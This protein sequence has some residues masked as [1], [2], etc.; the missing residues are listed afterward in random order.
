[1]TDPR[2]PRWFP[3]HARRETEPTHR[4]GHRYPPPTSPARANQP[5]YQ[6]GYGPT[7][8]P[9]VTESNPT[10]RLPQYWQQGQPPNAGQPSSGGAPPERPKSPRWLWI[11]AG[12]AVLLVVALGIALVIANGTAKKQTAVAPL[13]A[14]PGSSARASST[15]SAPPNTTSATDTP[16]ETTSAAGAE[17]VVYSVTGEGR[18]ISIT[19]V[20]DGGVRQTEFNVVLPWSKQVS[21]SSAQNTASVTIVNIGHDVTCTVTVGGNQVRQRTGV[22]LTTCNAAD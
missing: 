10:E 18:A 2:R 13:P 20:D 7:R 6:P 8:G 16:T 5:P 21:L 14:M 9:N 11:V 22:G 17:T 3:N 12:A 4:L 19:Y 1:M 15:T